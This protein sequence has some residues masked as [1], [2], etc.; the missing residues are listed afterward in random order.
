MSSIAKDKASLPTR[1]KDGVKF[2]KEL[3]KKD[4]LFEESYLNLNHGKSLCT[5]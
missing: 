5:V 3:R 2:G 4:F 1:T